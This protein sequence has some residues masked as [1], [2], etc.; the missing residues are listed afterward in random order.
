MLT[1]NEKQQLKALGAKLTTKYQVGKN[2]ISPTLIDVLD[3]ALTVKELIKITVMKSA[4]DPL[5]SIALD[6]SS[7]LN[8]DIVQVV[9]RVILLFR[10]NKEKPVIQFKK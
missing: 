7:K 8:A 9:G 10:R 3:K 2:E 6:L 1:T 4:S 5:M